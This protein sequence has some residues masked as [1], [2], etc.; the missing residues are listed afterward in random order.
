M[1]ALQRQVLLSGVVVAALFAPLGWLLANRISRP[2][3]AITR[4]A[5][6]LDRGEA[7]TG[8]A[9]QRGYHEVQVLSRTLAGLIANLQQREAELEHQTTHNSLTRLPNQALV[10]ALLGQMMAG[11][12]GEA[13]QIAVLA[14]DLDRFKT[15]NDA[16]GYAAGDAVL[17]RVAER[18][19]GCIGPARCWPA[20]ARMNWR[21]RRRR[22]SWPRPAATTSRAI[23]SAWP[24]P[25]TAWP[26]SCAKASRSPRSAG[27][28]QAPG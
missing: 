8:I 28:A 9:L 7:G 18:L 16:L 1:A 24:C 15:I 2:L 3:N 27:R 4:Q 17:L 26:P 22:A 11:S 6:R 21:P 23:T 20:W 12:D 13:P 19:Q 5:E 25:S 10:K 14:L